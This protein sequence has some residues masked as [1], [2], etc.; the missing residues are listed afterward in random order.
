MMRNDADIGAPD[1]G[2]TACEAEGDMRRKRGK[3][4]LGGGEW[5]SVNQNGL[6]TRKLL[7]FQFTRI[8]R[9]QEFSSC[10]YVL[11]TRGSSPW[12]TKMDN[13]LLFLF[14]SSLAYPA[15]K[16]ERRLPTIK[17]DWLRISGGFPDGRT[18]RLT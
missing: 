3:C 7:I 10:R 18:E 15:S 4:R 11:G 5:E 12:S 9:I 1:G 16:K 13:L 6:I 17:W 14:I 2:A 8:P